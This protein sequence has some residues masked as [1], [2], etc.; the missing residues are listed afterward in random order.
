MT[1]QYLAAMSPMI[2]KDLYESKICD[3]NNQCQGFP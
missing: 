1:Y 3:T 2:L